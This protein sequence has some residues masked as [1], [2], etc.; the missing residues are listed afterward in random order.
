MN[1]IILQ[2]KEIIRIFTEFRQELMQSYGNITYDSKQ[3]KSP[4]TELDIKVE[5]TIKEQIM[6]QFPDVGI[7]GEETTAVEPK[8]G[9]TWYLDPIDSTLSFIHGLPYCSNM[10]A[11][12]VDG[13]VVASV[14]YNFAT[15]EIFTAIRG[16]G[17]YKNSVKISIHDIPLASSCVFAD[18]FA[19]KNIYALYA[20]EE[21]RFYA[22]VGATGYFMT[23]LAQGSI[24]GICYATA[25]L[26]P[27]DVAP[28]VLLVQEAGGKFVSFNDRPFNYESRQFFAST[29]TLCQLTKQKLQKI[30][31]LM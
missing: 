11:C 9:V 1:E 29:P 18:A 27:H 22:P 2:Q 17:A 8:N 31:K 13:E 7:R 16:R 15:D 26:K 10:A 5:K 19:Y 14:I 24:Q 28:G 12:V 4:V 20:K 30:K 25:N 6:A 3:D 21:V 23:L